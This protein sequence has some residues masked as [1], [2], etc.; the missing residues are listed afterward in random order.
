MKYFLKY[1]IN[2]KVTYNFKRPL[3]NQEVIKQALIC[4]NNITLQE[5][6]WNE[7]KEM[8]I[9]GKESLVWM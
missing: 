3:K 1:C 7:I 2:T 9:Y 5:Y 6:Y 8:E 4:N